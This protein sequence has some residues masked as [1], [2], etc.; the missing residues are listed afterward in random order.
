VNVTITSVGYDYTSN[1]PVTEPQFSRM[2]EFFGAPYAVAGDSDWLVEAVAGQD[3]TVRILPGVGYGHGILDTSSAQVTLQLPAPQSGTVHHL[4]VANRYWQPPGGV[5]SFAFRAGTASAQIPAGR[6]DDPGVDDD[7]P[8]ALVPVTAGQTMPGTPIDL[9]TWP[10]KVISAG[11]LL[12]LPN[13]RRG[14]IA[15]VR[16]VP[17][18]RDLT[19]GSLAWLPLGTLGRLASKRRTTQHGP[20]G[21]VVPSMS[22]GFTLPARR[23]VDIVLSGLTMVSNVAAETS[24]Q[25]WLNGSLAVGWSIQ[26]PL[27]NRHQAFTLRAPMTL[28]AGGYNFDVRFDRTAGVGDLFLPAN[29]ATPLSLTIDDVG[30]A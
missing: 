7:Q 3:R 8:L 16:G 26:N 2:A 30:G 23:E 15:L 19:S 28:D 4:I 1:G 5:T 9:R 22:G 13:A 6:K 12:A 10:G 18:R 21:G 20:A 14:T 29:P 27:A 17:Y 25:V 24:L 11:S